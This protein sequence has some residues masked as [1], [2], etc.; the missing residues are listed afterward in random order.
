MRILTEDKYFELVEQ[1]ELLN[2][3]EEESSKR[4]AMGI[5]LALGRMEKTE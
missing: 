4:M 2:D 5:A 1:M 3:R